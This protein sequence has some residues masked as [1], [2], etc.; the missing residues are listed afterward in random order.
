MVLAVVVTGVSHGGSRSG[1]CVM[2]KKTGG[3]L[4][5]TEE[6]IRNM[7]FTHVNVSKLSDISVGYSEGTWVL[8]GKI[9]GK[10]Y[11]LA[12]G[13]TNETGEGHMIFRRDDK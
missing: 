7:C 4:M 9:E 6:D 11:V 2:L 1:T 5:F 12:E 3:C 13:K 8:I 10:L